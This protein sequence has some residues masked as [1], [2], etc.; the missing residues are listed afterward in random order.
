MSKLSKANK[1]LPVPVSE[2]ANLL[3]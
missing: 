2:S 3:L 1:T